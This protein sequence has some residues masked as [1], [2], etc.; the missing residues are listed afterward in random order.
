MM[1]N[2]SKDNTH[3]VHSELEILENLYERKRGEAV[4]RGKDASDAGT[5]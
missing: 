1:G 4:T 3:G 2:D 5:Y